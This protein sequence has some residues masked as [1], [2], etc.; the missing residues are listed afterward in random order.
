[1]NSFPSS[2]SDIECQRGSGTHPGAMTSGPPVPSR[3]ASRAALTSPPP[4][5]RS[6]FLALRTESPDAARK[7]PGLRR[8]KAR[9]PAP[10]LRRSRGI[11][12]TVARSRLADPP[13]RAPGRSGRARLGPLTRPRPQ[14]Q[15][16]LENLLGR[17]QA[18]EMAL[19]AADADLGIRDDR[20]CVR[21]VARGT[22]WSGVAMPEANRDAHVAQT[23]TP[24]SA[25]EQQIVDRCAQAPAAAVQEVVEEERLHLGAGEQTARSPGG[26]S[27][28]KRLKAGDA[29]GRSAQPDRQ[30]SHQA[31]RGPIPKHGSKWLPS[32]TSPPGAASGPR[33][34][35]T[36]PSTAPATTRSGNACA[37]AST[38][39][40]PP[41]SPISPK[42]PR[43]R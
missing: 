23:E 34:G 33:A 26:D 22:R 28:A 36:P 31:V 32:R 5:P 14:R 11:S 37:H 42:R 7:S 2:H 18:A 39:G 17:R 30:Q 38:Y 24:R 25:E 19:A 20:T 1:M 3:R 6:G 21:H 10:P 41:D 40:P 8:E 12:R 16:R 35:A 15:D 9:I 4:L 29:T 43:P 27:R 13:V